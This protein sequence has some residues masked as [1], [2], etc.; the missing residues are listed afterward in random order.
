MLISFSD[1][2]H[3]HG[4]K[5]RGVIHI[6][7]HDAQEFSDYVQNRVQ[8][9]IWI[10]ADPTIALRLKERFQELNNVLVFNHAISDVDNQNLKFFITNNEGMS[11]SILELGTHKQL[12][13]GIKVLSEIPVKS[14]TLDTLVEENNIDLEKYNF[15]NIDIQ[16][17]E[18][19]ALKGASKTLQHIDAVFAEVNTNHVY[20]GCAL[21]SEID[22]YLSTF[23]FERIATKM[24]EDEWIGIHPWGDALYKKTIKGNLS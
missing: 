7:A 20:K 19:L 1:V 10:E 9:M 22:D 2:V 12:F 6:G 17:A 15:L 24:W 14:K 4:V 11:S 18:L 8:D 21:M 3:K 23:G 13:P 16:G 5:P